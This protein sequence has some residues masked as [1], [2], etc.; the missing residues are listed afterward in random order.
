MLNLI[1]ES[2]T[3]RLIATAGTLAIMLGAAG[4]SD[5]LDADLPG[6]IPTELLNDA[7]NA[8]VLAA[9][10]V[11]DFE[12]AYNN[13]A[14][15]AAIFSD[16][17]LGAS[18]NLSAKQWGTKNISE[19]D[20]TNERAA[21]GTNAFGAYLPL[22]TARFQ[23]ED[24]LAR[25]NGWTNEE[26]GIDLA[27]HRVRTMVL[28][29][30]SYALLGEGFCSIR[31]DLAN[32]LMTPAQVLALAETKF[33]AA[34]TAA[35]ALPGAAGAE[36]TNLARVGRARVR[37]RLGNTS[38]AAAD[39][40]AVT[41]AFE[42]NVTRSADATSRYNKAYWL[43]TE[44]RHGSVDPA[45]RNLTVGGTPDTRVDV[46]YG[47]DIGQLPLAFDAATPLYVVNNKN[48]SRAAPMRL[49]SY[50][51]AQLIRA[52]ALGGQEAADIINAR[53][54]Q[55]SL[56][57]YSGGVDEASIRALVIDERNREFFME[58]GHRLNDLIRF[59]ITWKTG[60]DQNGVPY[61]PWRCFP[62]PT[63]ERIAAGG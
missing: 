32:S 6:R 26:A 8:A 25:L 35:T 15:S 30:Y 7:S 40:A 55:L 48:L 62:L 12:C 47:P 19:G 23:S 24:I 1:R 61:G 56:P 63:S 27:P 37:I 9:S 42:F 20:Q 34:L 31:M 59:N 14:A 4:C 38:G 57:A 50:I 17:F 53:R 49:A 44:Q 58:G 52:E 36:L 2:R 10:V 18:G 45:Y 46:R 16:Q 33:D 3:R 11:A 28:G 29:A 5:I 51:E 54:A 13:Y 41:S 39:A 22:H 21:C 43:V 60:N